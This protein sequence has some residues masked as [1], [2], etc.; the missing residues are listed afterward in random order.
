[1]MF[2]KLFSTNAQNKIPHSQFFMSN[3]VANS[4]KYI[5]FQMITHE[6]IPISR[7]I[8]KTMRDI[9]ITIFVLF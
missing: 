6:T 1:M 9:P 5:F 3:F 7:I 4:A 8:F 2:L